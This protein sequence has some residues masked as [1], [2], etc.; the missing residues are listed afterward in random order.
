MKIIKGEI[1]KRQ[2]LSVLIFALIQLVTLITPY[3]MGAIIDDYIPNRKKALIVIGIILFVTIPL[4]SVLLQTG[5]NY[6]IIK[7]V[8]K[9]GNELT[10]QIMERLV[11]KEKAYFDRENSL[12]LLSYS[13]K[14]AVGYINFYLADLSKFYVSI[15]IAAIIF[16]I[17]CFIDPILGVIQLL[18]LPF[19]IFPVRKIMGTVS[20]EVQTVVQRN[21]VINQIKG[22]VFKAIEF[23]KLCRLEQKKLAEVDRENESINKVWSKISV[24]DSLSGIWTS[25]FSKELFTGITFA[26]GALLIMTAD[27]LQVGQ[28]ISVLSYCALYYTHVNFVLMTAVDK[29]KKDS[30]YSSVFSYLEL[31]GERE[32]EGEKAEFELNDRIEFRDCHF[33]YNGTE[34]ILNGL[35]LEFQKGR[36]TGIVGASGGGK[37]TMLDIIMKLYNVSDGEVYIDGI[38]INAVNCFSIRDRVTK[39]TQDIFLFPGTIESNLKLMRPNITDTDIREA[40]NFACLGDY[41]NS[42][43]DGIRTDVGEAGKLMSGGERQRLSIA[44]G[45][46][47]NNKVLLLDE[48]TSS[49]DPQIEARLAENF[50]SLMDKGYTIISISHKIDFLKYA[51]T[52]YEIKDG[53]AQL[54]Q[55]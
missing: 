31:V 39:I 10:L 40:L 23:I 15:I 30:E 41:V 3:I 12:E 48:V 37:S 16:V 42:L 35:S 43:P 24:L 47:R 13:S 45:L 28:M 4:I 44:M 46:L 54:K 19:A 49:L 55:A 6:F 21:A 38:D 1:R 11:Y 50:H 27:K 53:K 32:K 7:Y 34:P 18:Y 33:S 2:I 26:A 51:D 14:E 9:K 22:D 17:L 52:V 36:W 25:G 29:K 20:R 5:Y 8:R